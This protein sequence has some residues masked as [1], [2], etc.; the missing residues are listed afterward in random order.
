MLQVREDGGLDQ[1]VRNGDQGESAWPGQNLR[2]E[3]VPDL[4]KSSVRAGR[5]TPQ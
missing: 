5:T 3:H 4:Q 2:R 1:S